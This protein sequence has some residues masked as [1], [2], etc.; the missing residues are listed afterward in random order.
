MESTTFFHFFRSISQI[1]TY[2]RQEKRITMAE[3]CVVHEKWTE[4]TFRPPLSESPSAKMILCRVL[5]GPMH[6][7]LGGLNSSLRWMTEDHSGDSGVIICG[8]RSESYKRQVHLVQLCVGMRTVL[9]HKSSGLLFSSALASFLGGECVNCDLPVLFVGADLASISVRLLA[10]KLV[11]HRCLDLTPLYSAWLA[12]SNKGGNGEPART[13][14]PS[15]HSRQTDA[16][17]LRGMFVQTFGALANWHS[18]NT[19]AI[20]DWSSPVLP[21]SLVLMATEVK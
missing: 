4:Y 5:A 18:D 20:F 8:V 13:A 14:L 10:S 15:I 2:Y 1:F 9:I 6:K 11:M 19:T 7:D 21:A 3:R 17:S 16:I 12:G